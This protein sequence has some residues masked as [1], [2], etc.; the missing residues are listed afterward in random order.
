V[1]RLCLLMLPATFGAGVYQ[2]SQL[3]DTFFATSLPQGSL[4][5]LKMADRLNQ[6]PLGIFGIALGTAILPMLARTSSSATTARRSGCRRTRS[7]SARC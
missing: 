4:T 6:M 3:V 7:R 5:L 1:K 2:I